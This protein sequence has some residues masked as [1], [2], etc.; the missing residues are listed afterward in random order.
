MLRGEAAPGLGRGVRYGLGAIQWSTPAG[1]ASGHSGFI[2]GYMSEVRHW[3][4]H[5]VTVA[6]QVNTS[7]FAAV[8]LPLGQLCDEVLELVLAA[9]EGER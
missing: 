3:P 8:G 2:P 4:D 5:D 6:V 9:R 1:E 7:D